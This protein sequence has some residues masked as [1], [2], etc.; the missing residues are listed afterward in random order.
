MPHGNMPPAP[1]LCYPVSSQRLYS[2]STL[3][4]ILQ[5]QQQQQQQQQHNKKKPDAK[6]HQKGWKHNRRKNNHQAHLPTASPTLPSPPSRITM[7]QE[8][9]RQ[10][11]GAARHAT[12]AQGSHLPACAHTLL[13]CPA[14]P[15]HR[16]VWPACLPAS[17]CLARPYLALPAPVLCMLYVCMY[18][19]GTCTAHAHEDFRRYGR[20]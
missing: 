3:P 15:A 19:H 9:E 7:Q 5:Q 4:P 11:S 16:I 13:F 2:K 12:L 20:G 18:L 17:P 8:T 1:S 6:T 14:S 10:Q